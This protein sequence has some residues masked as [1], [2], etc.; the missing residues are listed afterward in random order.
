M[1]RK[2]SKGE[3]NKQRPVPALESSKWITMGLHP[4]L[5]RWIE[6]YKAGVR[7]LQELDSSKL[8]LGRLNEAKSQL[9]DKISKRF[10]AELGPLIL[11]RLPDLAGGDVFYELSH[12]AA[13]AARKES[14][15][16]RIAWDIGL[17]EFDAQQR[18]HEPLQAIMRSHYRGVAEA[19]ANYSRL[20]NDRQSVRYGFGLPP[21]RGNVDHR[22]IM[23]TGLG[24]GLENLSAVALE[25]F[26]NGFCRCRPKDGNTARASD[27]EPANDHDADDLRKLRKRILHEGRE[28]RRNATPQY[29][30]T[31]QQVV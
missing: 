29:C 30:G 10:E 17:M 31:S 28:A 19:T 6:I 16:P 4:A 23:Q 27:E 2:K 26:F 14:G 18:F 20:E 24:W 21:F 15:D 11:Q 3:G 9:V 1:R 8:P 5:L 22:I 7:D 13:E 12:E 25:R